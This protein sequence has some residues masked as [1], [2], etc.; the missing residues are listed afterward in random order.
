MTFADSNNYE[1]LI[2]TAKHAVAH[3]HFGTAL[4]CVNK[5][6]EEKSTNKLLFKALHEVIAILKFTNN[7]PFS[8]PKFLVGHSSRVTSKTS[9]CCASRWAIPFS[10]NYCNL[11]EIEL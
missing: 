4:R 5:A 3:E 6:V 8:W 1:V 10:K 9:I 7:T 2:L 11:L